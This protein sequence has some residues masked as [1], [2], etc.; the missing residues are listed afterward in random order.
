MLRAIL[1]R[2]WYQKKLTVFTFLL[3]PLSFLFFILIFIRKKC[4]ELGLFKTVSLPVPVIVVGNITVGGTGKT[5][6]IIWLADYLQQQGFHPG[7]ISRGYGGKKHRDPVIVTELSQPKDIGDEA[8]LLKR[9]TQCPMVVCVDRVRAAQTLLEKNAKCDIILSDD[10][11][12]H[13]RLGRQVEIV[14]IDSARQLGNG[15][16]LPAGP[17]RELSS[18]L[19][20]VDCVIQNGVDMQLVGDQCVS[21]TNPTKKCSLDFFSGKKVHVVTAIGNPERFFLSLTKHNIDIIPHSYPDHYLFSRED[22]FFQDNYP[23]LM[24]EKDAVK[25]EKFSDERHWYLP[26]SV[27]VGKDI[28]DVVIPRLVCGIQKK[29]LDIV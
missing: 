22:I 3:L 20:K 5:P 1:E 21:L 6:F 12:Q 15:Y 16:L 4:F 14:L 9:R 19:K 23:V 8:L 25:C 11:L 26:V 24:T 17:L 29:I 2:H 13:Y 7:I 27:E 10:G 18:R 28:V